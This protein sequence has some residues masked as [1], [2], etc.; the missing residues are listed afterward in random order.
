MFSRDQYELVD[1][2]QGRKLER[3]AG[4]LVDRPCPA[5]EHTAQTDAAAWAAARL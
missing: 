4:V 2:G 1:F 5:A 3:F